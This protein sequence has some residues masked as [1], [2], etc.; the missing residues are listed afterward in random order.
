MRPRSL[1]LP[2]LLWCLLMLCPSISAAT[3]AAFPSVDKI[4]FQPY[5]LVTERHGTIPAEIG[6]F[7]VPQRYSAPDGPSF[8]LR[9]VRLPA[10]RQP[11]QSKTVMPPW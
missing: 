1:L 5:A 9:V 6:Y 7:E 11:V 10:S 8:R 2:P 3:Q 4:V